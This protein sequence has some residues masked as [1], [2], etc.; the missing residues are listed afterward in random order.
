MRFGWLKNRL[1]TPALVAG[2]LSS[3]AQPLLWVAPLGITLLFILTP[4]VNNIW[5]RMALLNALLIPLALG[6]V[7]LPWRELI[8]PSWQKVGWGL[9]AAAFLYIAGW[10]GFKLISFIAPDLA[11][12]TVG[13][14]AWADLLPA[15]VT[16]PLLIFI[17]IGEEIFWRAA[18]GLPVAGRFGPWWGVLASGLCMT[19][20][21]IPVGPP[22]LL[23]AAFVMGS[24]WAWLTI[25]SHSLVVPFICHLLWDL[26]VLFVWPY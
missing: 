17:V 5:Y 3:N 8:R 12:Q 21:H 1:P 23:I 6:F 9:A 16:V 10:L 14:Y 22:I 13:L 11:A 2:Q 7:S 15:A 26:L 24:F 4:L 25:R 20:A 19:L 18:I